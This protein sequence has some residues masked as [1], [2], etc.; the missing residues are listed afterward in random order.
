MT[1]RL[2]AFNQKGLEGGVNR[3]S[4]S[5]C[6]YLS[7]GGSAPRFLI[8]GIKRRTTS[9]RMESSRDRARQDRVDVDSASAHR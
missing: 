6:P 8:P 5:S 3:L 9:N 1:S 2:S 4:V 7:G